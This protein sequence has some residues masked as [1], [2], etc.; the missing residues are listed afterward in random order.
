MGHERLNSRKK[1]NR[2]S[3]GYFYGQVQGFTHGFHTP[4]DGRVSVLILVMHVALRFSVIVSGV[5]APSGHQGPSKG[6]LMDPSSMDKSQ[7]I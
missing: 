1:S 5:W 4:C 6:G 3:K 7:G 2:S